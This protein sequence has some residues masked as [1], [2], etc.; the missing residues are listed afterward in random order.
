MITLNNRKS[1]PHIHA[2]SEDCALG[3]N[4]RT[5]KSLWT[6]KSYQISYM[7]NK[8][9][10]LLTYRIWHTVVETPLQQCV[11]TLGKDTFPFSTTKQN[12]ETLL[13]GYWPFSLEWIPFHKYFLPRINLTSKVRASGRSFAIC[14]QN[15]RLLST[16]LSKAENLNL[17]QELSRCII[18][19]Q[20]GS[21]FL[22]L[23]VLSRSH[24]HIADAISPINAK[25]EWDI[26][27]TS[28]T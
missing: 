6:W 5:P 18:A 16:L 7:S 11:L 20:Q 21:A 28:H 4:H 25:V 27:G 14:A 8:E 24:R 10:H 2:L 13:L 19:L 26:E 12:T 17:S 9:R 23:G 3:L 15:I 22:S 1:H